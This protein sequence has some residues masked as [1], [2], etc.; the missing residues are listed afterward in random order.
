MQQGRQDYLPPRPEFYLSHASGGGWWDLALS[1]LEFGRTAFRFWGAVSPSWQ[2]RRQA[3]FPFL[4]S[5]QSWSIAGAHVYGW[6]G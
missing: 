5:F 6:D 4:S 2:W 1:H 3:L